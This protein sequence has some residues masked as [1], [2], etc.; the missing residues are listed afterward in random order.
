[1]KYNI[2]FASTGGMTIE[3]NS[4]NEAMEIFENEMQETAEHELHLNGIDITEIS[5]LED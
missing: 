5:E 2:T 4:E 1:M 3:A